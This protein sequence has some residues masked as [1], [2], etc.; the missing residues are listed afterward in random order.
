MIPTTRNQPSK[1]WRM[2]QFW[3]GDKLR[4][5]SLSA[6][7]H[8]FRA[9]RSAVATCGLTD[10]LA[11]LNAMRAA[12][13]AANRADVD[14][15]D[16]VELQHQAVLFRDIF[17]NPFRPVSIPPACRTPT[18]TALAAAAYEEH[19]L[20]SGELYKARLAVLADALEEAGCD[21][22]DILNHCRGEGPHVRGCWVVDLLLGQG[23]AGGRL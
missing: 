10:R 13:Q 6:D 18:V 3:R 12:A 7:P 1:Q 20:P 5:Y 19:S 11:A 22:A 21:D 2:R 9:A 17:G 14:C 16:S 15:C 23:C 8:Q 4:Q